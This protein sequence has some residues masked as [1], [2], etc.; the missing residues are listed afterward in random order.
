MA[1]YSI[2]SLNYASSGSK[3][4]CVNMDLSVGFHPNVLGT[5]RNEDGLSVV[6][7][8]T[9][10]SAF[11]VNN[12]NQLQSGVL[13]RNMTFAVD[14]VGLS[15]TLSGEQNTLI[16]NDST[17][18]INPMYNVVDVTVKSFVGKQNDVKNPNFTNDDGFVDSYAPTLD[19]NP[20]EFCSMFGKTFILTE[21]TTRKP[22]SLVTDLEDNRDFVG[23]VMYSM[24]MDGR[25]IEEIRYESLANLRAFPGDKFQCSSLNQFLERC[26]PEEDDE[27]QTE[28]Y[29]SAIQR[30]FHDRY[31][32]GD[33]KY[34]YV[35]DL[36][37]TET[38][39]RY[40][41]GSVRGQAIPTKN[42]FGQLYSQD[43]NS[44]NTLQNFRKYIGIGSTGGSVYLKYYDNFNYSRSS[45]RE[46]NGSQRSRDSGP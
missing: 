13:L 1:L 16:K 43:Q 39:L 11:S 45:Y 12:E 15:K 8:G 17:E 40:D 33:V 22:H 35:L 20:V 10:M 31:R 3:R 27:Q 2:R 29:L 7:D 44:V 18:S 23:D 24:K 34:G 25:E 21:G 9:Q 26:L 46:E 41:D 36:D 4:G 5:E 6:S 28:D 14:A 32:H 37:Q 38:K 42:S 19:G 30:I